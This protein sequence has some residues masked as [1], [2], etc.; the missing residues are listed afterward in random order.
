MGVKLTRTP[1]TVYLLSDDQLFGSVYLF[2]RNKL[3]MF[4][5]MSSPIIR[6]TSLYLQLLILTTDIAG[7]W[8]HG[9]DGHQSAAV[10]VGNIRSCK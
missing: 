4:R 8:F 6:S 10:S 1:S 3:Y 9:L 7:G 5:A 2:I